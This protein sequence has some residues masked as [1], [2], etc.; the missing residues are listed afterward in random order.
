[1]D[2]ATQRKWDQASKTFDFMSGLGPER[3]WAPQKR[4][5][6][7]G[8]SGK[9]LFVALGTG[10]DI[11][12]FPPGQEIVGLDISPRMLECAAPRIAAYPGRIEARAMDVHDLD[13]PDATFDQIYTSCTFCS[14]PDPVGGLRQLRR[15]LKPGGKL[16]MFE[17]T[18]SRF[19]PFSTI[20]QMLTP[21]TRKLGPEMNR[22]TEDNV[23]AA[24][25]EIERI[26]YVYLDVV[27]KIY[28][29]APA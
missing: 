14:V 6:F 9:V 29:T 22:R 8:M 12:F 7:S 11:A 26:E 1:M 20:M 25:F 21:L 4:D 17:H 2:L 23:R 10:L 15:V 24:G 28:A 16:R 19:F 5:L 27:K 18:G 3:R 13:Y